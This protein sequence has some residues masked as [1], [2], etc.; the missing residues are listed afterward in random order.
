MDKIAFSKKFNAI[1]KEKNITSQHLSDICE[2]SPTHIR[3]MSCASNLPSLPVLVKLCNI[4]DVTPN[5]LLSDSLDIK[6]GDELEDKLALLSP[7]QIK[8]VT[9]VVNSLI[10]LR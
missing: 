10:D 2:L 4:L 5:Y 7:E 6:N 1:R 9:S 3:K 8:I